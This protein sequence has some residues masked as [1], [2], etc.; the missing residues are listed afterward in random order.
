MPILPPSSSTS[1]TCRCEWRPSRWLTRALRVLAVLAALSVL[2]SE[3]PRA[4][5]WP[6]A[7]AALAWGMWSARRYRRRA[8]RSLCW[9]AGRLP[10][11]D[12]AIARGAAVHWRG[13]LAFLR[14]RDADGRVRRL[15][16]W[17]DTLPSATRRELRLVARAVPDTPAA[18]SMAP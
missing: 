14:W 10:E 3:M 1:V 13:P 11:I 9:A 2:A 8:P 15:A 6:L 7:A 12:G 18:P 5:A 16:W 4:T 17:P